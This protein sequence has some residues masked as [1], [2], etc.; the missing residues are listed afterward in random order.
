MAAGDFTIDTGSPRQ[1]GNVYHLVGTIEVDEVPRAIAILPTSKVL[2]DCM[3]V[4]TD[5]VGSAN[6]N[7]NQNAAGTATNGSLRAF[8]NHQAVETYR[9]VAHFI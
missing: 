2:L 1:Q 5:G 8:G 9:F 4:D 3:V 6:V 7:I